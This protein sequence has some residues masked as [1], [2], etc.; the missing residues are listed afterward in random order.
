MDQN[1]KKAIIIGLLIGF[2]IMGIAFIGMAMSTYTN[3]SKFVYGT[4][5]ED[6]GITYAYQLSSG[7]IQ[8]FQATV[9]YTK[10]SVNI[11]ECENLSADQRAWYDTNLII[12]ASNVSTTTATITQPKAVKI[13]IGTPYTFSIA[14][15]SYNYQEARAVISSPDNKIF[16]SRDFKG[17]GDY[18]VRIWYE[19]SN[20]PTNWYSDNPVIYSIRV[21]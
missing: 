16:E 8:I 20:N 12:C 13:S 5:D 3:E 17:R 1:R 9:N 21:S 4:L 19:N 14:A 15:M 7:T 6:R 18:F 2:G 10:T 11:K